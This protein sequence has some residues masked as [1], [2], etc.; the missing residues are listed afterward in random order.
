[1]G[2]DRLIV[3]VHTLVINHGDTRWPAS[4]PPPNFPS[5]LADEWETLAREGGFKT[6]AQAKRAGV[7]A[8]QPFIAPELF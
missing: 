6:N 5:L 8:A 2:V 4:S 3:G 1:M 7:K